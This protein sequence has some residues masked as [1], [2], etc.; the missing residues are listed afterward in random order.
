MIL[1]SA[2]KQTPLFPVVPFLDSFWDSSFA[3]G[4]TNTQG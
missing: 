4:G 2:P 3:L 1:G